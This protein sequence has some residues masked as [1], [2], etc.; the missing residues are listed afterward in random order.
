MFSEALLSFSSFF[1][2]CF[3]SLLSVSLSVCHT[4]QQLFGR[5]QK[6]EE[7]KSKRKIIRDERNE[8]VLSKLQTTA[9]NH[10]TKIS[11]SLTPS[12]SSNSSILAHLSLGQMVSRIRRAPRAPTWEERDKTKVLD[13]TLF[14]V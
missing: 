14:Y 10:L 1:L 7:G 6:M 13:G 3:F 9:K 8:L 2:V 5:S 12:S 4:K 11:L